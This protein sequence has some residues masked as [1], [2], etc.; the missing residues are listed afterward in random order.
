MYTEKKSVVARDKDQGNGWKKFQLTF[1]DSYVCI[2]VIFDRYDVID[3]PW[4]KTLQCFKRTLNR[5]YLVEHSYTS[6]LAWNTGKTEKWYKKG[7]SSKT[8]NK[9]FKH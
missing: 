4:D 2:V 9:P 3:Y 1:L 6:Y 5:T 8:Q 7:I